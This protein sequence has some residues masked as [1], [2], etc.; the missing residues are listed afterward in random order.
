MNISYSMYRRF[1][2]YSKREKNNI[3]SKSLVILAVHFFLFEIRKYSRTEKF[4][5]GKSA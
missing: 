1:E 3:Y 4:W 2:A 5:M